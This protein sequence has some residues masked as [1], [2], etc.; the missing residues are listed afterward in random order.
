MLAY[1]IVNGTDFPASRLANQ[2]VL[3]PSNGTPLY[4]NARDGGATVE[5]VGVGGNAK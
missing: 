2:T 5:L 4:V 1:H 3:T